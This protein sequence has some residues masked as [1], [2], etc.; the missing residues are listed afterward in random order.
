MQNIL[1]LAILTI[2]IAQAQSAAPATPATPPTGSTDSTTRQA[3]PPA[4]VLPSRELHGKVGLVRGVVAKLDPIR[5]QLTVRR[6]GGSDIRINFD[7]RTQLPAGSTLTRLSTLPVGSVVS[8]DTVI[9]NGKLFARSVRISSANA[10]EL[11]GQVVDYDATRSQLTL[12]DPLSPENVSLRVAPSTKILDRGKPATSQTLS[13]GMLVR[14]WFSAAQHMASQVEI[15]AE[16]GNSFT[17]EG[18]I[19]SVDLRSRVIALSN[20]TDQS[21]WELAFGTLDS[22]SL[23]LLQEGA[24]VNIQAE[25]DGERYNIRTVTPV[26]G[27]P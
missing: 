16:R 12:H 6:F 21:L 27:N 18:R 10:V 25:F 1:L 7:G 22:T 8:V 13:S 5:D 14:V 15:L 23:G 17:F 11:S 24:D 2:G 9:D 20:N 26:L 3:A 19:I 4:D